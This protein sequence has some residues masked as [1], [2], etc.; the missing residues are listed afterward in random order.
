VTEVGPFGLLLDYG[1]VLTGPVT[2]SFVAFERAHGLP[3]GTVI[4]LLVGA[5]RTADGGVIGALERGEL[6]DGEFDA[7]LSSLLEQAGHPVPP[8]TLLSGLFA[9]MKPAGRLWEVARRARLAGIRT[10]L[11]SNSWGTGMYPR[12]RLDAVFDVQVISGEVGLRKPDPAIYHLAIER[13]GVASSRCAFVDDLPR[14]V[15]VARQLGMFAVL[16]GGDDGATV[17][18]LAGFLGGVVDPGPGACP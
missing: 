17:A 10:G 12:E 13:L 15:E 18:T 6:T 1:G 8:G 14:N 16:H 4:E 11:L 5:S 2:P 7:S 9:A 3:T